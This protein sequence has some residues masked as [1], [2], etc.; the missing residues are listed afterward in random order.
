MSFQKIDRRT[1]VKATGKT[2]G[3]G[4]IIGYSVPSIWSIPALGKTTSSFVPNVFVS[5]HPDG[6]VE[7]VCHRSEMGQGVRTAL[8]MILAE[9]LGANYDTIKL[10]Q[11]DGDKKYGDQNTDGSTSVRVHWDILRKAGAAARTVLIEAAAKKHGLP[12]NELETENSFVWHKKSDKKF[13]FSEFVEDAAKLPLPKDPKLKSP[14]QFRLI[15]RTQKM[16]DLPEII[17]GTAGF[18]IDVVRPEMV[19]ASIERC[20]VVK[21]KIKSLKSDEAMKMA[22]VLKV[23]KIEAIGP[24]VNCNEGVAV[25]AKNS[26]S[27]AKA[28]EL[29]SIEWDFGKAS[30]NSST[31]SKDFK[32]ALAGEG[33]NFRTTGKKPKNGE[34]IKVGGPYLTPYLVHSPMEPL[35]CVADVKKSSCEIWGPLQDPQRAQAAIAKYLKLPVEKVKV[36]ITM[37]GGGFGRKSQ[38]DFVLE[39]VQVSKAVKKPVKLQWTREDEI[40]HGFYHADSMQ[41]IAV[42]VDPKEKKITSWHHKTSFPTI[43]T[44]FNE[45]ASEV[46]DWEVGMGALEFPYDVPHVQVDGAAVPTDLRIGWFRAV[47]HVWHAFAINSCLDEVAHHFKEDPIEFRLRQL[48]ADRLASFN[49]RE[50]TLPYKQN[51]ERLRT[52]IDTLKRNISWKPNKAKGRGMGFAA[53]YSFYSYI[54][55]AV[56]ASV[57]NGVVK[58]HQVDLAVD[59]GTIVNPDTVRAQMEGAVIFGLSAAM[60]GKITVTGGR[61]DQSNFHDY[62]LLRNNEAPKINVYLVANNE[63]PTGVGEPGVPPIAPALCNAIFA[64]VG[65]RITTLPISDNKLS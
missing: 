65:K 4:L 58:V 40:Q 45:Q 12:A 5:I 33:K 54:A 44:V 60:Q 32:K 31:R 2:V 11:G 1:F 55:V 56:D 63:L 47:C 29:L 51:T 21:G 38:P 30:E 57:E 15:G 25:V 24:D 39:A 3:S 34:K 22:N 28:R 42:E 49:P 6:L 20:P 10:V 59:A 53:H 16:R 19:Y 64:A 23:V 37:L 26:W 36:H 43:M 17:R 52:T 9:E 14:G 61:V 7:I 62:P 50:K 27:A 18:G 41:E 46:A 8:P 35:V 48:G 13:P